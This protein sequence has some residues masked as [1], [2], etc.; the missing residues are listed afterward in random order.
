M[1]TASIT[2]SLAGKV[3]LKPIT[4]P[5]LNMEIT[6]GEYGDV[7]HADRSGAFAIT[8]ASL[9]LA[10]TDVPGGRDH[11][12]VVVTRDADTENQLKL[13]LRVGGIVF[14][15]VPATE[16]SGFEGNTLLPGSMYALVRGW[17]VHRAGGVS[18]AQLFA[19]T[20]QE[21][22]KPDADVVGSL[23]TWATVERL[24]GSWE[25]VLG[26]HPDWASIVATVGDPEDLVVL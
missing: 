14:V 19:L 16:V 17:T 24:Y 2:P 9:P 13:L 8:G 21:V 10:V 7:G 25:A 18:D 4:H 22:R 15:H 3:W 5:S 12:L 6:P 23:L 20:L 26:A 1:E 11:T